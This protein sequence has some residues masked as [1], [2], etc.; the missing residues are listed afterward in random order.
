MEH[1]TTAV[2]AQVQMNKEKKKPTSTLVEENR[3]RS[4]QK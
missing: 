3:V 4:D 2:P 1:R